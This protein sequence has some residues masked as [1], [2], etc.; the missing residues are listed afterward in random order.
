MKVKYEFYRNGKLVGVTVNRFHLSLKQSELFK[1]YF[2]KEFITFSKYENVDIQISSSSD[3]GS[4]LEASDI[5]Y[6]A[7]KKVGNYER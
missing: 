2:L 1:S 4:L 5:G 7:F 3:E 6:I